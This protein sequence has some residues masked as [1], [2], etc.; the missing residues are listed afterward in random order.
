MDQK[1]GPVP[2]LVLDPKILK[3]AR[4]YS[5]FGYIGVVIRGLLSHIET[6]QNDRSAGWREKDD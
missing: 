2:I 1:A 4:S 3:Q 6:L 5:V